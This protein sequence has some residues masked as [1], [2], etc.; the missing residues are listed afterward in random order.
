V[1]LNKEKRIHLIEDYSLK[2]GGRLRMLEVWQGKAG[3]YRI[4][5]PIPKGEGDRGKFGGNAG[6]ST[7]GKR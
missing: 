3:S 1:K 2:K 5:I 6:F 7:G 4:A